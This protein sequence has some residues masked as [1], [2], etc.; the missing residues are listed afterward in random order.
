VPQPRSVLF[1]P[2]ALALLIHASTSRATEPG[3]QVSVGVIETDNVQR[4]PSG[5]SSNTIFE[6]EANFTWHEQRP[7][8]NADIEA[9]LS[10]LTYVPRAFSDEV[11]GNFIGSARVAM[12]PQYLFWNISDNF[13]QGVTD[14]TQ[15][16]TP[17]NR[18]NINFFSTG[19]QALLPLSSV[20]IL[21]LNGTYGRASYQDSPLNSQRFGG[22][23][24]YIH[25]LSAAAEISVNV[26]QER[27]D[28]SNDTLNPDYNLQEAFGHFG[29][30]GQRTTLGIDAGYDRVT[31]LAGLSSGGVLGRIQLSRKVSAS[32]TVSLSVGRQF[33]DS[34]GAFQMSQ[35]LG[36][37]NLNT[38]QTVQVGGPFNM[39]FIT[40]GWNF[41][42]NRTQF[43][44]EVSHF[45]D[46]YVENALSDD[47]RTEVSLHISRL[48]RPTVRL[49][50]SE[51]LDRQVFENQPGTATDSTTDMRLTWQMS[52]R[53]SMTFAYDHARRTSDVAASQFTQN[54]VWVSIGYGR[55]AQVPTGPAAPPLPLPMAVSQTR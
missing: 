12:V 4:L 48:L 25:M 24:G 3:Y 53:I 17:L 45:R 9:D 29:I 13:G 26:H 19:P 35:V 6:Q 47:N 22:G 20:D 50:I 32:S 40:G 5:G 54:T 21:D 36:G 34:V 2:V 18:E 51:F 15:A 49:A 14:P 30:K 39:T 41:L 46:T 38:Q 11:I 33:S 42:H 16:V 55:T 8:L 52:R 27:I 31:G 37:A 1:M 10:H 43:G 23:G 28:Y 7:V 44:V